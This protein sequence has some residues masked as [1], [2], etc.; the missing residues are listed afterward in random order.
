M[1]NASKE[2]IVSAHKELVEM[3]PAPMHTMLQREPREEAI[4]RCLSEKKWLLSMFHLQVCSLE[5]VFAGH[6]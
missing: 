3:S 2:E 1:V 5:I 4:R 6:N